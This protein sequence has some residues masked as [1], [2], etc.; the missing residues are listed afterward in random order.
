MQDSDSN[1]KEKKNSRRPSGMPSDS[2]YQRTE[3]GA[4]GSSLLVR[5]TLMGP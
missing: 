2:E 4:C 5:S 3:K 1:Q